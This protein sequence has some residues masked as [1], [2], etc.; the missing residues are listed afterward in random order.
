MATQG[1]R[2]SISM[3]NFRELK[4][5]EKSHNLALAVYKASAKFP[6]DEIYGLTS[7]IRRCEVSALA[8]IAEGCGRSSKSDFARF[9]QFSTGKFQWVQPVNWSTIYC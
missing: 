5:W 3:R 7:Q 8:N 6:R 4:V 9:L 1:Q 2:I